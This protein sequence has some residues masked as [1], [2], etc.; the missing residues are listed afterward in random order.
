MFHDSEKKYFYV[1][2][3]TI[4]ILFGHDI[5]SMSSIVFP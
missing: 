1:F 4:M 3:Y 5:T 2:T